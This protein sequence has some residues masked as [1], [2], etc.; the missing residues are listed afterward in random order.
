MDKVALLTRILASITAAGLLSTAFVADTLTVDTV[1]PTD[2]FQ[3]QTARDSLGM[4][5]LLLAAGASGLLAAFALTVSPTVPGG[6]N[7]PFADVA[8]ILRR[9]YGGCL[10][11][12]TAAVLLLFP[13]VV[14]V[15]FTASDIT[16]P[17]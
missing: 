14:V 4:V 16:R 10:A 3:N 6:R 12:A 5:L 1:G 13:A 11:V 7:S 15:I 9:W 2:F 17:S 8:R